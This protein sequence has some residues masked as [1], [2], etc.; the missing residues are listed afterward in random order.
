[1]EP[2][3]NDT[4][5]TTLQNHANHLNGLVERINSLRKI[6]GLLLAPSALTGSQL[7]QGFE[8]I[9]DLKGVIEA[10][11][12]QSTLKLA[13][14]SFSESSDGVGVE[15]TTQSRKR[16]RPPTPTPES[17]RPPPSAPDYIFPPSSRQTRLTVGDLPS[18]IRSHN[19]SGSLIKLHIWSPTRHE[20]QN[21]PD[22]PSWLLNSKE[23][24]IRASIP[25]VMYVYMRF[26]VED[27]GSPGSASQ[28]TLLI[29]NISAFGPGERKSPHSQ[30][31]YMVFQKLS[32]HLAWMIQAEPN[33][34]LDS[35]VGLFASYD[36]LFV[37]QC[38]A[39]H[40]VL[41]EGH[42]PPVCR[43]WV[44]PRKTVHQKENGTAEETSE[45]GKWEPRHRTCFSV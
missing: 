6:P 1:M 42:Y 27:T 5:I 14:E 20:P 28:K 11:T 39:C 40:R 19:A 10:D 4:N 15:S 26:E 29:E 31:D 23:V 25:D 34:Q 43:I 13:Q 45:G 35:L 8:Q 37:S 2:S 33:V 18:F 16:K 30:S 44:L 17:S 32:Q 9:K 41:S 21:K 3:N 36:D 24:I 22:A 12:T 7:E 38:T